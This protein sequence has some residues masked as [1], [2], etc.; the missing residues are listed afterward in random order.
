MTE[1]YE[2]SMALD[3]NTLISEGIGTEYL[4]VRIGTKPTAYLITLQRAR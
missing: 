1:S 4:P 3:V 2:S